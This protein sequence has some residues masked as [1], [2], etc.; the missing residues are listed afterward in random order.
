MAVKKKANKKKTESL[1]PQEAAQVQMPTIAPLP[2]DFG[3][4]D[5]NLMAAK[6][7]EIIGSL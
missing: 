4:E 5:L 7:N 2:T 1:L 3:R 6:I